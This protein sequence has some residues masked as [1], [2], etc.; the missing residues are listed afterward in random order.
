MSRTPRGRSIGALAVS[1]GTMLALIAPTAPAHAETRYRQINQA[2]ITAVAADSATATDPI[3]NTLD[4]NPDTI[5]HTTWQN[6]KDPLPHWI[7]FKLG[8]EAVNLGKVEITPRSSSNGSGRMHDYELY[9]ANTKTCNNAAFSSAKPVATGS[10]GASDTSIRKITFAATKATCVKVKVNSSWG[11]D[12][13]NEEVSSMAEFN[14]FTVDGSDPSPD[15]TPSE[16]PTPEV[17]KDAISLS[18]GTVT[19]RARRDF[20]QVI[21][22]TVGH[23]HMAGRI[24]SP[25][26]KVRI[27]GADHVATVSAPTTTGSSASWKLTFRDLPG[28]EL[29]ADIK[30]SDGVMTWS[31]PHIVDTPDHRV[32]TVSVPG[33]T[34][35]SVTSTDP[36]A[37][38]SSANIVV[39]R[40]KTG[41]LFQPLATADVSQDTSWVAMANDST[42]AAGFEDNATQ[43]GLVGSA[44][45]V[46]RF[47]HSISQVGGTKVGAIEPATWVHRGKGSATPC[48]TD[49]FGNKAVC[50]L[51]GGGAVKDGIGPDPDTPYVRVKIVADANADGKV[52][53]QDAAVATRDVTMKPT[54]SGDV[55]NKV[56]THIPFNIVSQ[57]THPFLRTL[58]DVKRISLATDG[59]GQQVLLKGYQA[60][61]HDYAHPDYG[62]NVSHRAGG[63]KD[64]EKLT[65]SGRQ[66]NTDFGIHVNLVESY[67]EANHFGDN[68]LVKPHQKAWDWMEQSYRM[69]YAKDL[70]SGQLFARLNQLRKELGAKSNLDWLYFDTNYPAGWQN[71][72]IANALNAEGWRIGSEWSSTYPRYN[73]WSHW[74]NDENY[75]TG[76]KGYSSRIIRFIDNSRR[77]T[78]NP[79][80]ILG[81]SNVV[82]YEG[83]TSHNDYNAF[84]ANVWQRNLPTKFLQRSDI[85]SWQD[86]RIAFANG[87]VAT[88]SKKSISGHEIPTARTITFDG[89]T[90]FKEGGSYLLPWSNG[91][92]DRLYYWNP[93]NGSATW[94]LTNSWAAQK[95]VTLFMLTDTGR[96]KVAE[97]PVT[98]GSIRIPATKAK[99]AYV[100]Y[101]TS[102]VPVAKTPNWGEGSHFVNPGFYSG[103]TAGWNARGNVSVK[104]N[105]RGNFHLEFGKAQSQISQVLNLPAG[106]HSL[107][108]WV[109]IDPTKTRPVG[110][111]VDGTGVTPIDHQKGCGGHAESVITS[112][113]AINATAS[114]EY[115]GT[116]HQRLRVAFHSDGRPATVTL[117]ALAGNAV[118]SADDFRVVDA[119]VPSDPHVTPATVLFQNFED[120]DTGYWPF[121]TGSA[122]MEGDARTQLSR[123]HEPYTQKGWNGRAMDSVLSGDWSLKMHEERNG[124]VLR[125]TTASAPLTGDGTRYRVSFDYQADKPGYSFVTG[126]D[127]VNGKA[128]KEVITESHAMGVATSTTHFSTDIVVKD[129]PAWIGFTHQGEGDMSIDNLR[130]EK[131]DPRP[132][133]ATSTQTAVFPDACKPAPEPIQPAQPS[134]SAPTTSG[135]SQVPGT[136]NRSNR[137]ALPRTGT[138]GAGL[139]FS[140]SE[141]ASA[142]AAVDVPRQGR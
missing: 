136:G 90:V 62:G 83:W 22:Y 121:V 26:T 43:D 40:N 97:I 112:T 9:T 14:A 69:D 32:N 79:D 128:V 49:S 34:L 137:Y 80:P 107:W 129:Q 46:A 123:R 85:M 13:S 44:A 68:I 81:N 23:A 57:A 8:D 117:K 27:N 42:L 70:G 108:A 65:E 100:L 63:M 48:P 82:E 86:G 75:G 3:S 29:T 64:L 18:D 95:S 12:G 103:D 118:V 61:G 119:A 36:K 11:G 66:W 126:H 35:A 74:A 20:P 31:I 139:G 55:A 7:V 6:G 10:Y 99:T 114:D 89:A 16:P 142:T 92:S 52:D 54:G 39:D 101:P 135:S 45:T 96:V 76:N 41:D 102:K 24:G 140:S 111:A 133:S 17:P 122:G 56:I 141:A 47:V 15:P 2:A 109:Q 53:W 77:D 71:D 130:I 93:G 127:K 116:Y 106:D 73:Q 1:A 72:R 120:V 58:D 91:G 131:L 134:A 84:I 78:W 4:G 37:Q 94:K 110:L 125:T 67:P 104:H 98:N 33:L 113:T 132:A 105:D 30:V 19:V 124:T 25:L 5:W 38:L 115:F 28:V 60:E 21:D 59:L 50:Q 88:S 51:P 138:D 87:T